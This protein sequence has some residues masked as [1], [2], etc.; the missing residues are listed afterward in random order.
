[1][2]TW[3]VAV[4]GPLLSADAQLATALRHNSP[5]TFV[6]ELFADLGNPTVALPVLVAAMAYAAVTGRVRRWLP[7]LCAVLPVVGAVVVVTVLKFWLGRP[8]PIGGINYY[9]SGH[10]AMAA[11]AFGGAALLLSLSVPGL[12]T[13]HCGPRRVSHAVVQRGSD[14]ARLSLAAGCAGELVS[15]LGADGLGNRP[16]TAGTSAQRAG[17]AGLLTAVALR[18]ALTP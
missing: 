15:G 14:L 1:M 12:R 3:Q 10:T 6:A 4:A 8:G 7:P 9:P 11:V 18:P 2:I 13:G 5:P 16:G 17:R